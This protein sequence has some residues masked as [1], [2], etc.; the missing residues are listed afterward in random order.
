MSYIALYS[1]SG[2]PPF[3]QSVADCIHDA[4]GMESVMLVGFSDLLGGGFLPSD[5]QSFL[6]K[7][8]GMPNATVKYRPN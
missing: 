4:G 2:L 6:A 1:L 5:L 3:F 8:S 7:V